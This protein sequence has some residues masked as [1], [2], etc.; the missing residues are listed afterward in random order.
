MKRLVIVTQY[1]PPEMGAPQ[2][3]WLE[4][5]NGLRLLGWDVKV[6]TAMPNYP[7][8]RILDGYRGK[9]SVTE[10]IAGLTVWRYWLYA[11]NSRKALPR[12]LSM[13]SFSFTALFSA[14]KV[15]RARP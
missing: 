2:S 13:L 1:F 4:T 10:Q 8:G 6:V 9:F 11:S 7:T 5:A 12:I 3:R 14:F 15:R